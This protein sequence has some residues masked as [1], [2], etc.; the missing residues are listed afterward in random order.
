M[1]TRESK[2]H[3]SKAPT[4]GNQ[5]EN[6]R[7][8][9]CFSFGSVSGEIQRSR[10]STGHVLGRGQHAWDT[11]GWDPS[12]AGIHGVFWARR[13]IHGIP[14]DGPQSSRGTTGWFA[15]GSIIAENFTRCNINIAFQV[16]LPEAFT[17]RG[18]YEAYSATPNRWLTS[19]RRN[20][21]LQ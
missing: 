13:G 10:E 8:I 2:V 12:I 6:P 7:Y 14:R 19:P 20:K 5:Q 3:S 16:D 21:T 15:R 9:R 1:P 17:V 18:L 4:K 11:A